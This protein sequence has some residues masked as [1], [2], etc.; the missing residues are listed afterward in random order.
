MFCVECGRESQGVLCTECAARLLPVVKLPPRIS[1]P[2]CR[3]CG[4]LLVDGSWR[5]IEL[6]DAATRV[7]LERL[8]MK[9]AH[10]NV[11]ISPEDDRNWRVTIILTREVEGVERTE[12]HITRIS[13]TNRLCERCGQRGGRYYEAIV[14]LR[15]DE[16]MSTELSDAVEYIEKRV[17]AIAERDRNAFVTRVEG[18]RGGVDI[19]LSS[20]SAARLIAK[21]LAER[22]GA[23]TSSSRS[24]Y[25]MKGGREVYRSTHLVRLPPYRRGDFLLH[26]G[27]VCQVLSLSSKTVKLKALDTWEVLAS[28]P[29][30]LVEAVIL[31]GRERLVE[32]VIVSEGEMELQVLDPEMCT[33]EVLKPRGWARSGDTARL[34]KHDDTY[35]LV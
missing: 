6:G 5:E 33:V 4:A 2:V 15:A 35:Y 12:R 28:R 32:A 22:T 3:R 23:L 7:I 29:K 9:D 13:L 20:K 26:Q 14:Q 10:L 17:A 34:L 27:R 31:G 24:I 8:K 21:T 25:G 16:R 30:D 11:H 18:V 1:I 19:Y